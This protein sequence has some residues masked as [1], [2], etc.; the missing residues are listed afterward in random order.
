MKNMIRNR[1]WGLCVMMTVAPFPSR[2]PASQPSGTWQAAPS[3]LHARAAHAVVSTGTELY[4]LG[5]TGAGGKPVLEVERFDGKRWIE[6][7][8][9]P[10]N[11]LNAPAAA[12]VN[13][14]IYLLGGFN[15]TTNVPSD[16]LL[17][18]DLTTHA[19]SEGAPLPAPRGGHAAVVLDGK[20]HLLGGGNSRST[21]ADHSVFDPATNR[22]ADAAVLPRSEGS[23]AVVAFQHRIY[24]I[25]GRSGPSD[26]GD[27]YIYDPSADR[28]TSGPSIDPRGTAGAVAY[29]GAI[30]LFGGESQ[31]R[32]ETLG[33]VFRL[34]VGDSTWSRETP[35]PTRRNFARAVTLGDD[36]YVVGGSEL[37]G[38]SHSSAGSTI[39]E[40]FRQVN[41]PRRPPA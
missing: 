21:I 7:T 33:D 31:A 13:G 32:N 29:C 1:V 17:V 34:G 8:T 24:A 30:Y 5:G 37:P 39:V 36:V 12:V 6:E 2:E 35:M 25:G 10:G 3:M 38:S 14:R 16:H 15:T 18:Y 26:F 11:G 28:W 41:C 22:W 23:P 27:V 40:R 20:I 4:A 19:W 9:L